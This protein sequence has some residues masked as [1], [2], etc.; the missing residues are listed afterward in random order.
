MLVGLGPRPDATPYLEVAVSLP[1]PTASN[2][3]SEWD[4][5]NMRRHVM[6]YETQSVGSEAV[7]I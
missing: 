2:H 4:A 5:L 7:S 1:L 3:Y 6:L